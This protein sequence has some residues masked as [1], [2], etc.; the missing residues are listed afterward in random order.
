MVDSGRPKSVLLLFA[1]VYSG[2]NERRHDYALCS[3]VCRLHHA[4]ATVESGVDVSDAYYAVMSDTI[5]TFKNRLGAHWKHRDFL[6]HYRARYTETG[7]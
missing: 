1:V 4:P 6:F 3:T 5:S 7:D 2:K